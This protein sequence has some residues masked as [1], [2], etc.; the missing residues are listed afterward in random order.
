ML[1]NLEPTMFSLSMINLSLAALTV[2]EEV[3]YPAME[4]Y[5]VDIAVSAEGRTF[6]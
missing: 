1:T 3:L 2:V 6:N 4:D 5:V